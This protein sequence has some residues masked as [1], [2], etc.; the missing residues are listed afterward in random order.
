MR[1]YMA[2]IASIAMLAATA[3]FGRSWAVPPTGTDQLLALVSPADNGIGTAIPHRS[4]QPTQNPM[5]TSAMVSAPLA[6]TAGRAGGGAHGAIGSFHGGAFHG[7]AFPGEAFHGRAF[8]GEPFR[9]HPY[10]HHEHNHFGLGFGFGYHPYAY[11]Y[12]PY[13]YYPYGYYPYGYYPYGYYPY[14]YYPYGYY[15][16]NPGYSYPYFYFSW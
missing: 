3:A 12:Y 6:L 16:G 9:V 4:D 13:G 15:Y 10:Y 1:T 8:P 7:R 14:G 5:Q 2:M 11:G